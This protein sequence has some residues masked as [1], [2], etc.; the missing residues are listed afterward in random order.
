MSTVPKPKLLYYETNLVVL[1][2]VISSLGLTQDTWSAPIT[3]NTALPVAKGEFVFREQFVISQ[4][5][6]APS[7]THQDRTV[8]SAVS[9]L[10]FG[11]TGKLAVFGILP[12]VNKDLD[13]TVSGQRRNRNADGLGDTSLFGRYTLYQQDWPGRTL[14]V[15]PF[16]GFKAPTGKDDERDS[17][18]RLPPS[19][20]A[21]TGSWDAFG[22]VVASYQTLDYEID[23]QISYRG[24]GQTSRFE[25]GDEARLDASLQYRLWPRILGAGVPGFWYG[26]IE[27]NLVYQEK[28]QVSD[29][30]DPDSGGTRWFLTPG[31]Q[32]V[33]KRWVF[34]G[35]VQLPVVQDLNGSALENDYIVRAGFRVN[36]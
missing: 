25:A 12:Y 19:V 35:A 20:Q 11:I 1:I 8:W 2:A 5:G 36:F 30:V 29:E 28:N 17:L 21:G 24:N 16:A 14:R 27:S 10:G 18:G 15:A 13:L 6:H 33:T 7:A 32:Y 4:S 31:F 34:E 22:G 3:F 23:S 9:V 26:V